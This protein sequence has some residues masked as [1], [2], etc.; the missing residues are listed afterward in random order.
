MGDLVPACPESPRGR[1]RR[2]LSTGTCVGLSA[3]TRG[4]QAW[5]SHRSC[6]SSTVASPAGGGAVDG[7]DTDSSAGPPSQGR[8]H[9]SLV[10]RLTACRTTTCPSFSPP[11]RFRSVA[12]WPG[13][14]GSSPTP[15]T[16]ATATA[17]DEVRAVRPE[18]ARRAAQLPRRGAAALPPCSR[19]RPDDLDRVVDRRWD[20]PS[21]WPCTSSASGRL[22]AARRAAGLRPGPPRRLGEAPRPSA[23]RWPRPAHVFAVVV[24]GLVAG[25]RWIG[26][27]HR[28]R[29]QSH[30]DARAR[31][32]GSSPQW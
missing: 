11:T 21:R 6:S 7:L 27:A 23:P 29:L 26:S 16:P 28:R 24:G 32:P 12:T 30:D 10:W 20:P 9:G 18:S 2:D 15:T 8:P 22:P 14:V 31:R 17:E 19:Y 1:G 13:G 3:T 25:F 5:T 4:V